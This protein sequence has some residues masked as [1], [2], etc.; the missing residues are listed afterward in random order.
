MKKF[1]IALGILFLLSACTA[2]PPVS[3]PVPDWTA[4]F[5]PPTETAIPV[6]TDT[7]SPTSTPVP[8]PTLIRVLQGPGDV[9][10]PILLF[11]RID[12]SPTDNR[13]YVSPEKFER[14]IIAIKEMD[15]TTITTEMLVE[16]INHGTELPEH[17]ILITFDDGHLDNYTNAFP[18]MQKYGFTGVIY[19]VENYMGVDGFMNREQILEM[20]TAG[21]EVGSHGLSHYDL[22]KLS[23]N[24]QKTE[25]QWSKTRLEKE[26]GIE[27]LTFAYPFGAM[28]EL[29]IGY[30]RAA[31]YIAAMGAEGYTD[32]QGKWNL[33]NLQR[34]EIKSTDDENSFTRFLTWRGKSE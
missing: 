2:S 24:D 17:P 10:I 8:S 16:T 31:G 25:I 9:N 6:L 14:V 19:I 32:N 23:N 4:T 5:P 34:V 33:Y 20:H 15:Y 7:P 12:I 22:S 21:W 3:T 28:N 1:N 18:I 13:Y 11:H 26:L 30:V 27:I 29:T